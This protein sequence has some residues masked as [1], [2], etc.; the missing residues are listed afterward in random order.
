M[1]GE[2]GFEPTSPGSKPGVLTAERLANRCGERA[3]RPQRTCCS[4]SSS[5]GPVAGEGRVHD[6]TSND[7]QTAANVIP[8]A[9][10]AILIFSLVVMVV[11][12]P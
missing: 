9:M 4:N 10:I 12:I 2:V 11:T 5:V 3:P 7:T 6:Q 1:A 8:N